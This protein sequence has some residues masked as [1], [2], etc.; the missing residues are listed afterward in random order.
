[1]TSKLTGTND[2][3]T[4]RE[5]AGLLRSA[6]SESRHHVEHIIPR[7]VRGSKLYGD[8]ID[9]DPPLPIPNR[10]VK[11]VGADGTAKAGE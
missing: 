11:P 7:R 4:F 5:Y 1:M 10:D 3:T 8:H 9:G 6:R 2:P